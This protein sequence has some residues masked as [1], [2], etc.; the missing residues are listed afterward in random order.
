MLDRWIPIAAAVLGVAGGAGGAYVG[1]TVAN[2]GQQERF[3]NERVVRM[4]ELRRE[5]YVN[6]IRELETHFYVGGLPAKTR[7]AQA[8]VE[9]VS[10]PAIRQAATEATAAAN[11]SDLKR[12]TRAR[13]KF[14]DLA[15][16]EIARER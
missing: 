1:G 12:Y 2:E 8:A 11:T 4:Q 9:L 3:R 7:A 16:Q 6:Y 5:T 14:I 15:Q 10:S 13:D